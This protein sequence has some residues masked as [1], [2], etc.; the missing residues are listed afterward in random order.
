[1]SK[2]L[3]TRSAI[4]RG[5]ELCADSKEQILKNSNTMNE[6]INTLFKDIFDPSIKKYIE[7]NDVLSEAL[8]KVT[9]KMDDL[10]EYCDKVL[11]WY[12]KYNNL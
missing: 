9:R 6:N 11:T 2:I 1:M 12:D 8:E 7:L 4:V 3:L 10:G 5:K